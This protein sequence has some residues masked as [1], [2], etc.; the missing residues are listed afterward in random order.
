VH[1]ASGIPC[2]LTLLK[3]REFL[4]NLGR[5][6]SRDR[7]GMSCPVIASVAKQSRLLTRLELDCFASLAMTKEW[8]FE[9]LHQH[10][11]CRPGHRAGTHNP[12]CSCGAMLERQFYQQQAVVGMGPGA[13][14]GTT[15]RRVSSTPAS[16][17]GYPAKRSALRFRSARRG[18]LPSG[19][20]RS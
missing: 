2:A 13:E 14:A 11:R 19:N 9:N 1:R 4:A 18:R 15:T 6:A 17:L 3:A 8:L 7:G 5:V 10:T 20:G 12:K 16:R